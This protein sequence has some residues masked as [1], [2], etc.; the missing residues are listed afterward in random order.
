MNTMPLRMMIRAG[1]PAPARPPVSA[2]EKPIRIGSCARAP[3][4]HDAEA[5][6]TATA[7]AA[8]AALRSTERRVV[9][10]VALLIILLTSLCSRRSAGRV[11]CWD[12][13]SCACEPPLSSSRASERGVAIQ[14]LD[15]YAP[16][17]R[18]Q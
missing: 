17:G 14:V 6:A 5:A 9:L 13:E 15:C 8:I 12:R 4:D 7:L 11:Q 2:M 18:S 3:S 16:A 10:V 1:W